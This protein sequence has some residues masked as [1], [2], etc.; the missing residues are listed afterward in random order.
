MRTAHGIFF[1]EQFDICC[2]RSVM[3]GLLQLSF[4]LRRSL[5]ALILYITSYHQICNF[6]HMHRTPHKS[7]RNEDYFIL[8]YYYALKLTYSH[9]V[10]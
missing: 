4:E 3:K 5:F 9:Q 1:L 6:K 7:P 2:F 10:T 8:P